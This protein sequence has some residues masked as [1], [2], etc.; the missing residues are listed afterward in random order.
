MNC[1]YGKVW[2]IK[3]INDATIRAWGEFGELMSEER[4]FSDEEI[5]RMKVD[6]SVYRKII[7]YKDSFRL[8]QPQVCYNIIYDWLNLY[9]V[10]GLN[11][12]FDKVMERLHMQKVRKLE[13][14]YD[15]RVFVM[16]GLHYDALKVLAK[17]LSDYTGKTISVTWLFILITEEWAENCANRLI[18]DAKPI[19]V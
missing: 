17:M 1:A 19:F 14:N 3:E 13:D 11:K 12:L 8:T 2:E 9:G 18:M 15:S 16:F 10:D 4:L 5:R 7:L 6:K